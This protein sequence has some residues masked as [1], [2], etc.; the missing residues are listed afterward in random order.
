MAAQ[1]NHPR[2]MIEPNYLPPVMLQRAASP[3]ILFQTTVGIVETFRK[4]PTFRS[5]QISQEVNMIRDAKDFLLV[6]FV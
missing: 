5:F 6:T 2:D 3:L 1:N 4:T